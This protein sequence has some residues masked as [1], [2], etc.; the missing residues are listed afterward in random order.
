MTQGDKNIDVDIEIDVE[1][2]KD[3][4]VDGNVIDVEASREEIKKDL[5]DSGYKCK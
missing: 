2:Q 3:Q 1:K 4:K 5:E